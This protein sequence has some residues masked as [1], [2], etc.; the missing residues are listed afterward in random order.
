MICDRFPFTFTPP[1][2]VCFANSNESLKAKYFINIDSRFNI[3][4]GLNLVFVP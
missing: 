2:V 4:I 3:I 1:N